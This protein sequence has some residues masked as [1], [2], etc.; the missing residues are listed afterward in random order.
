M[1]LLFFFLMIRRPP[2]STLFPYTTLFRSHPGGE[3]RAGWDRV[4]GAYRA[5]RPSHGGHVRCQ[6]RAGIRLDLADGP[7]YWQGRGREDERG[8]GDGAEG[9]AGGQEG[10]GDEHGPCP[11]AGGRVRYRDRAGAEGDGLGALRAGDGPGNDARGALGGDPGIHD[12]VLRVAG[13]GLPGSGGARDRKSTRLNSSHANISYAVFCLK[14]KKKNKN[15]SR[16]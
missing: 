2:R 13:D 10:A 7:V 6:P 16:I 14:K 12:D 3:S 5:A 1:Y 11:L 9:G 15:N 8:G 4:R